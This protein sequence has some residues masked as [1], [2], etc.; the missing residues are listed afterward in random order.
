MAVSNG[1]IKGMNKKSM[2][3]LFSLVKAKSP[4]IHQITNTVTIN[5][6]ANV[7]LAIGASPVMAANP[8]E[9]AD[10]VQLA[11]ALV[12]NFGT[13]TDSTYLA[14]V[15]AGKVANHKNIP[16][17]FDPVG[18]GA[19]HYR[20]D[21]ASEL[22]QQVD[23]SVIR[24]N[25]SEVYTLIGGTATTRGVDSGKITISQKELAQKAATSCKCITVISGEQDVVSDG[26]KTILIDNGDNWLP[27]I[28]G[29][30]CMS[31]SLIACFA[32]ITDNLLS[33]SIVGMSA[34]SIAGELA[35]RKIKNKEGIGSFKM[36]LMDEIFLLNAST[37]EKEVLLYDA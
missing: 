25:A 9:V 20:T 7:T 21:K 19:T 16:V 13:I 6:C 37:W 2:K 3:Q 23:V 8:E 24:G 4:L 34:M 32:S 17:I 30:G 26:K 12:I 5:D 14:M 29:T 11:D 18:V 35:K 33:A 36:K 31:T 27:K 1:V 15:R 22:L 10:M 28:T